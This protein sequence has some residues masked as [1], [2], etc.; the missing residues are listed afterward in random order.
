MRGL[1]SG[2]II[3]SMGYYIRPGKE[4]G[5][6][7]DSIIPLRERACE[8]LSRPDEF[9]T[10]ITL[11]P[12]IISFA[13]ALG[14]RIKISQREL[15]PELFLEEG[16]RLI[17]GAAFNSENAPKNLLER[18][19]EEYLELFI[20]LPGLAHL[21][22]N[23]LGEE[24]NV[25]L[26]MSPGTPVITDLIMQGHFALL[27]PETK[28]KLQERKERKER[29][30]QIEEFRTTSDKFYMDCLTYS[31]HVLQSAYLDGSTY[32]IDPILGLNEAYELKQKKL[33]DLD[34]EFLSR[35]RYSVGDDGEGVDLSHLNVRVDLSGNR[36][37]KLFEL[38]VVFEPSKGELLP[39]GS[40]K[41]IEISWAN[42]EENQNPPWVLN[43]VLGPENPLIGIINNIRSD[44]GKASLVMDLTEKTQE[45]E[46]QLFMIANGERKN[47]QMNQ[48][49]L[50]FS[51]DR[52]M[53]EY[54]IEDIRQAVE[55]IG[56]FFLH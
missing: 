38:W 24:V 30:S 54:K 23:R 45:F 19:R 3:T 20:S 14:N 29:E 13:G 2:I 4:A 46:P 35:V 18:S 6:N 12:S 40:A 37:C 7:F 32:E 56:L 8:I 36:K 50:S 28:Y 17:L 31:M 11:E 27:D 33:E 9:E 16:T 21:V 15:S 10:D 43:Y 52:S 5:S 55:S 25:L 48:R 42:T 47:F 22:D 34:L 41:R 51:D 49:T 53:E 39:F 44:N 1:D 26:E